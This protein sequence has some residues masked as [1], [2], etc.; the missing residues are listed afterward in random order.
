MVLNTDGIEP[1]SNLMLQR[2]RILASIHCNSLEETGILSDT[3]Q[4]S[5]VCLAK[6][7]KSIQTLWI[8]SNC[9]IYG[10]VV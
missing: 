2:E 3:A 5:V 9:I 1:A 8:S 6:K 7:K 10:L 4:V